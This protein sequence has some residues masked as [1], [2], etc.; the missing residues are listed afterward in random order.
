MLAHY[1]SGM[2]LPPIGAFLGQAAPV[3]QALSDPR[4]YGFLWSL[5][6]L[7]RR[8]ALYRIALRRCD[9]AVAEIP[10]AHSNR[11][12][13][14]LARRARNQLSPHVHRYPLWIAHDLAEFV[15]DRLSG[16]WFDATGV[17][18]GAGIRRAWE[19][20]R[21]Q[22]SPHPQTAYVLLWLCALRSL[23]EDLG[24]E[25]LRGG[26]A[27]PAAANQDVAVPGV[28]AP[29]WG[30]AGRKP[31]PLRRKALWQPRQVADALR[32]LSPPS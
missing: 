21:G 25:P 6:P 26:E 24:L 11:P 2:L 29:P 9:P 16:A 31:D 22:P 28:Q 15:D 7:V 23:V 10:D 14:P 20:I 4:T 32:C 3:H 19:S 17:L 27:L 12:P 8:E 1:I 13:V 18:D 30:Y 5:S